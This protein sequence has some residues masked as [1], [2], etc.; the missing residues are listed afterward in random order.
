MKNSIRKKLAKIAAIALAVLLV[1]TAADFS[2]A[3]A[4]ETQTESLRG[5][6]A[7]AIENA[8]EDTV[9]ITRQSESA[10][11]EETVYVI[12]D[13]AGNAQKLIVSDWLRNPDGADT[14]G[15]YSELS[16]IVNTSG[17]E[18]FSA[19]GENAYLWN[20]AGSDIH[21]QGTTDKALPMTVAVTYY[22]DG[23]ETVPAEIAGKSGHVAIRFTYTNN[24]LENAA[25]NAR[26]DGESY[27]PF[28]MVSGLILSN[29]AFSN[30]T[31]SSGTVF[32]DGSRNIVIG[33]AIPGLSEQLDIDDEDLDIPDYVEISA[34]TTDFSLDGT[35]TVGTT[36]MLNDVEINTD[37]ELDDLQDSLDD[38]DD[39]ALKLLD[40]TQDLYEGSKEFYEKMDDLVSGADSLRDGA[41]ELSDGAGRVG[42]GAATLRD[43]L[44]KLSANSGS[45]DSG[46]DAL[47][48]AV[49]D[50]ATTQL[51][52]KLVSGGLMTSEQASA[53]TLTLS[54]YASVF[55][56]LSDAAAVTPEQAEAGIRA[57]LSAM[58]EDQQNLAMTIAFDRMAADPSLSYTDALT[59]AGAMM[60]DAAAAQ[61]ACAVIDGAWLA[62]E[63]HQALIAQVMGATGADETTAAKIAAVALALDSENPAAKISDAAVILGNAS[64]VAAT[65]ADP[66]KISALCTAVASAATSTGNAQLDAVKSQLDQVSQFYYGL[67]AYTGGVDSAYDGSKE[68]ASGADSLSSGA[69]DLYSGAF[70]LYTGSKELASGAEELSGGCLDLKEGMRKFYD[71]GI[72][73]LLDAM[74]GDY[75]D[76]LDRLKTTAQAGRDY[77]S[78]SGIADGMT[79]SVKFIFRTDS[80]D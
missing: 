39:A 40:G 51:R 9:K 57:Q 61:A 8:I 74:D 30:V 12:A 22:L 28:L 16:D 44:A 35:L 48:G 75:S 38:L 24:S 64:V 70:K 21:Y 68:L 78:F 73:K 80:V 60:A 13:A 27:I 53:V 37:G 59:Q 42:S 49:F 58:T 18:T 20:A 4:E 36:D 50:G 56:G 66:D 52:E 62:D 69:N 26:E 29:D 6:D 31:V 11:K 7:D 71:D 76:L 10:D 15:D 41:R 47:V 25:A 72:A 33:Y 3:S 1:G 77:Q 46:A 23:R 65:S 34:D 17:D 5:Q 54:N 67:L 79:G 2:Y 55:A 14:I 43:G 45:L 19:A 63:G 32:N